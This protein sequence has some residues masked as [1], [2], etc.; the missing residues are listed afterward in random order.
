MPS[1]DKGGGQLVQAR[2]FPLESPGAGFLI[3]D[4]PAHSDKR[5]P[6]LLFKLPHLWLRLDN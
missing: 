4:L 2:G 3:S 6:C 1:E 5:N